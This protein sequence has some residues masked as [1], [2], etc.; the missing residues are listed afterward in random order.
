MQST[1]K[2]LKMLVFSGSRRVPRL[3]LINTKFQGSKDISSC[4]KN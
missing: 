1:P 2:K 4:L 3:F